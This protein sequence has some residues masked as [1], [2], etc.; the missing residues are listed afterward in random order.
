MPKLLGIRT[1]KGLTGRSGRRGSSFRVVLQVTEFV[2]GARSLGLDV[3]HGS[4][5]CKEYVK[6][7]F[8]TNTNT[9]TQSSPAFSLT[10]CDYTIGGYTVKVL[11]RVTGWRGGGRRQAWVT[12]FSRNN[13]QHQICSSDT[14]YSAVNYF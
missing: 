10:L 11:A 8:F 6:T 5:R 7:L 9:H 1:G 14:K 13:R 12:R 4:C 3:V 2:F